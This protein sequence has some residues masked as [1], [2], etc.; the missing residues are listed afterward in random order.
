[1]GHT[2]FEVEGSPLL[3]LAAPRLTADWRSF[4]K[5][6]KGLGLPT[7]TE[8]G[9]EE[10][11]KTLSEEVATGLATRLGTGEGAGGA[12]PLPLPRTLPPPSLRPDMVDEEAVG[13][14]SSQAL[15]YGRAGG[16]EGWFGPEQP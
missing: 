11:D 9:G 4:A 10:P 6:G 8:A 1:M 16:A 14:E 7:E 12:S 3:G 13:V 2:S 5:P 15:R